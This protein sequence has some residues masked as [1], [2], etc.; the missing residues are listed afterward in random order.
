[1]AGLPRLNSLTHIRV[2]PTV[3]FAIEEVPGTTRVEHCHSKWPLSRVFYLHAR[4]HC[5]KL[6]SLPLIS[7]DENIWIMESIPSP[8]F[9]LKIVLRRT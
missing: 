1:M 5:R 4:L 6:M 7:K 3:R 8:T 9:F 2:I